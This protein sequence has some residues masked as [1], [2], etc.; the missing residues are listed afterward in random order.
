MLDYRHRSIGCRSG[1]EE[2]HRSDKLELSQSLKS[3][4][5]QLAC[6]RVM[7][8]KFG[9]FCRLQWESSQRA[10]SASDIDREEMSGEISQPDP[11]QIPAI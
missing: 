6:C 8:P 4:E 3:T 1:L 7:C 5:P 2:C 10:F 11:R 9:S